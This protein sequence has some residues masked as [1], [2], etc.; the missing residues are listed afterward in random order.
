MKKFAAAAVFALAGSAAFAGGYSE[1]V[2]EAPVVV[3]ETSSSSAGYVVPL[4]VLALVAAA[5]AAD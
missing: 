5:V 1:P 2:I 3:E 4:L